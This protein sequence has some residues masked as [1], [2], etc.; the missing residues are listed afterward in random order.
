MIELVPGAPN[1]ALRSDG[2]VRRCGLVGRCGLNDD[3]QLSVGRGATTADCTTRGRADAS[4]GTA[5]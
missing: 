4:G 5:A 1:A 3:P 2:D